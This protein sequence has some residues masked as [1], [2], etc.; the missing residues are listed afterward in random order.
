MRIEGQPI[1]SRANPARSGGARSSGFAALV[2]AAATAPPTS[3]PIAL[4]GAFPIEPDA[5]AGGRRSRGLDAGRTL[6]DD[7][8]SLRRALLVG[9]VCSAR[10]GEMAARLDALPS[11]EEPVLAEIID[12]IRLR[13]AVEIAK[14]SPAH[15]AAC[16]FPARPV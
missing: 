13:V 16:R 2:G 9:N 4:A 14:L 3:A 10:L 1:V 8:E 5:D 6:L 7:L 12:E 11:G 15:L